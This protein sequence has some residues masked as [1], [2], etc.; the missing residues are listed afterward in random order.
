MCRL[1]R[2]DV[3]SQSSFLSL[4]R[5]FSPSKR[6]PANSFLYISIIPR[7]SV[8]LPSHLDIIGVHHIRIFLSNL[9]F[10]LL[11]AT[12]LNRLSMF[13]LP[14]LQTLCSLSHTSQEPIQLCS[15]HHNIDQELFRILAQHSSGT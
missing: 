8:T 2:G 10:I 15:H 7:T 12:A 1:L 11:I 13:A 5:F 14:L 4:Y 6:D 3:I 9:L